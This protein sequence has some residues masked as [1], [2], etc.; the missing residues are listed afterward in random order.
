MVERFTKFKKVR[1]LVASHFGNGWP[2]SNVNAEI[3][4]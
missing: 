2:L 3:R 1:E 4:Q